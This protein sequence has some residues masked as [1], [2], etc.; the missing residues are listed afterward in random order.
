MEKTVLTSSQ[1]KKKIKKRDSLASDGKKEILETLNWDIIKQVEK[2]VDKIFHDVY[3]TDDLSDLT[4]QDRYRAYYKHNQNMNERKRCAEMMNDTVKEELVMKLWSELHD[5]WRNKR[6]RMEDG[7]YEPKIKKTKDENRIKE[8]WTE[9]VDIANTTFIDLPAD[10]QKENYEAAK[11][12]IDLVFNKVISVYTENKG[13]YKYIFNF[14]AIEKLSSKVHDAWMERNPWS[15]K[16]DPELFVKYFKL[17][18]TEKAKDREQVLKAIE[19]VV[20]KM[21]EHAHEIGMY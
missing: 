14:D 19:M 8:N 7:T 3:H 12:V 10:W 4:P 20:S 21:L 9:E 15:K 17:P 11:C 1:E 18:E 6:N 2:V 13:H 5:A 16:S